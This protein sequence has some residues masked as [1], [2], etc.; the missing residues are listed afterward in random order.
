MNADRIP[1]ACPPTD[2]GGSSPTRPVRRILVV[3]DDSDIRK[4]VS[5][6]LKQSGYE[7]ETAADGLA[8]WEALNT[9]CYD[10]L[11]TDQNMPRMTGVE[12]I[13]KLRAVLNL[14]PVILVSGMMPTEEMSKHPW[15]QIEA[16]MFKP[17]GGDELLATVNEILFRH[18]ALER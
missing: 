16:V 13:K 8:A 3:D 10:L 15:L 18:D 7:V 12:L 1:L 6:V 14:M 5:V 11:L 17:Y 9:E 4:L 2:V